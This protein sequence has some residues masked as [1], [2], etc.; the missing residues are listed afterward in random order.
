MST[1][2]CYVE[3]ENGAVLDASLR[4]LTF[5]RGLAAEA[6]E[7]SALIAGPP[8]A[9]VTAQLQSFGVTSICV[10]SAGGLTGY[11]PLAL[12]K[13]LAAMA[14]RSEAAAVVA[15]ATDH[16]NE[17]LAHL[18][19][20]TGLELAANCTKAHLVEGEGRFRLV[21]QRWGGSLIE[22]AVL[23]AATGLFSVAADS[24]QPVP[25]PAAGSLAVSEIA[26]QLDALDLA[27]QALESPEES[28]GISLASAKVV[29]SGG[30]GVGGPEGFAVIE[31]LAALLGGAVG[32]SRV[33]TSLGWR[34]HREQVGQ[35]GTRVAPDLYLA[36]GISGAVQHLAGCQSSKH[37]VAVNT[38]PS[39]PIMSRADY[40]VI[41]SVAEV[42]PALVDAIR[43]RRSSC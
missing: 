28:P 6:T 39:A 33:V 35:T 13:A 17:V 15:A 20:L 40:A 26:P 22:E 8:G 14:S 4:A 43:A 12:A 2:V 25:S 16:G 29:V 37:M 24:V 38:D 42:L 36:C 30:R 3:T 23:S 10:L 19:A 7:V 31:E 27:L 1:V 5:A 21:R 9:D 32:V 18:G 34:P 41:G 11:A